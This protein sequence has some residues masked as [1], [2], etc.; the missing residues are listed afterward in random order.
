MAAVGETGAVAR[1]FVHLLE[2]W[3]VGVNV[4]P[5]A[6]NVVDLV[7]HHRRLEYV[8]QHRLDGH[9]IDAA[10]GQQ[11]RM[12]VGD[13]LHHGADV[14]VESDQIDC[15]VGIRPGQAVALGSAPDDQNQR[16]PHARAASIRSSSSIRA[17]PVR[18]VVLGGERAYSPRWTDSDLRIT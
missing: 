17:T 7:G 2:E 4:S 10:V 18:A 1:S 9:G 12:T 11:D 3:R 6:Q 14:D 5:A 15:R 8:L 16:P 13:E